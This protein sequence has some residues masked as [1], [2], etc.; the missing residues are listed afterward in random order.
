LTP[1][2][3]NQIPEQAQALKMSEED[4]VKKVMLKDTVNGEFVGVDE[5]ASACLF[6]ASF[7]SNAMTGQSLIVSNGWFME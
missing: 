4:V 1:L 2:V 3:A 5:I 6:F 7:E